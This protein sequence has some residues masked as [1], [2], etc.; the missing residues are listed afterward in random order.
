[1]Q[2]M[3]LWSDRAMYEVICMHSRNINNPMRDVK[4]RVPL[5][6][7]LLLV[8]WC[9]LLCGDTYNTQSLRKKQCRKARNFFRTICFRYVHIRNFDKS[10]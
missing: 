1:M 5:V 9:L 8:S 6:A 2:A 4:R 10:L 3:V 7:A